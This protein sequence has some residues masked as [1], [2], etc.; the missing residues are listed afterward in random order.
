VKWRCQRCRLGCSSQ[1]LT[2]WDLWAERLSNT[3]WMPR[4]AGTWRSIHLKKASTSRPVWVSRTSWRISGYRA[5][6]SAGYGRS[7][8]VTFSR[9]TANPTPRLPG[10][11][12]DSPERRLWRIVFRFNRPMTAHMGGCLASSP[13]RRGC[14]S[15]QMPGSWDA[16]EVVS[17]LIQEVEPRAS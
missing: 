3:T 9:G 14:H 13:S 11:E 7:P 12:L 8:D 16:L 5:A 2:G 10:L 6:T 15:V 1:V 4:S 17:A